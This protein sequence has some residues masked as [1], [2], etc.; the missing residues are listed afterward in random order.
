VIA[1]AFVSSCYLAARP[2]RLQ[3]HDRGVVIEQK[4]KDAETVPWEDIKRY[5]YYDELMLHSLKVSLRSHETVSML[6]YWWRMSAWWPSCGL[7]MPSA[8]GIQ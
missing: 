3:I 7:E 1:V 5:A 8:P 4:K 2:A 6:P